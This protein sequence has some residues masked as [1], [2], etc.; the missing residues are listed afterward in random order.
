TPRAAQPLAAIAAIG[1]LTPDQ[2]HNAAALIDG[3]P[4]P[5]RTATQTPATAAVLVCGL[6]LDD[7]ASMRARQ[8]APVT[9][10]AGDDARRELERLDP[11]LR[12]VRP[13]QK[14]PLLQLALPAVR[15]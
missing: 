10:H 14:L 2:I 5:L 1:T 9:E 7:D 11:S 12:L 6:L 3:V 15:Q 4:S 13:E 8:F